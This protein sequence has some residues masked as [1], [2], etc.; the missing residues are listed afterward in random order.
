MTTD[1]ED[2][3]DA[4]RSTAATIVELLV[5]LAMIARSCVNNGA[6]DTPI[7]RPRSASDSVSSGRVE[8]RRSVSSAA[9]ANPI[10]AQLHP[11]KKM[12]PRRRSCTPRW[13]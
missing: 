8:H 13:T 2:V 10:G 1:P 12:Q 3:L 9:S 7:G 5:M 4:R 6:Y 11:H